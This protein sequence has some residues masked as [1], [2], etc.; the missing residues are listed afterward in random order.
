MSSIPPNKQM[1][2]LSHDS[3]PDGVLVGNWPLNV[4]KGKP[5]TFTPSSILPFTPSNITTLSSMSSSS[6][7]SVSSIPTS[8]ILENRPVVVKGKG[9]RKTT[10]TVSF[11]G[12]GDTKSPFESGTI[13]SNIFPGINLNLESYQPPKNQPSFNT[14]Q[15]DAS[16]DSTALVD[17]F[18]RL[19][20]HT[21]PRRKTDDIV[22]GKIASLFGSSPSKGSPSTDSP[23]TDSPVLASIHSKRQGTPSNGQK[24]PSRSLRASKKA[25][26]SLETITHFYTIAAFLLGEPEKSQ[27]PLAFFKQGELYTIQQVSKTMAARIAKFVFER[28]PFEQLIAVGIKFPLQTYSHITKM[29]FNKVSLSEAEEDS[30]SGSFLCSSSKGNK[31]VKYEQRVKC[32]ELAHDY[33]AIEEFTADNCDVD[34]QS[35]KYLE[36]MTK[37]VHLA[38]TNDKTITD[39]AIIPRTHLLRR[40][41]TLDLTGT[42]LTD[43]TLDAVAKHTRRLTSL[44]LAGTQVKSLE[45]IGALTLLRALDLSG[46]TNIT[47]E[48]LA[49]LHRC[50]LLHK[51]NV[52]KCAI[53]DAGLKHLAKINLLDEVN[54]SHC[55]GEKITFTG[56]RNSFETHE[57][58]RV[59][60]LFGVPLKETERELITKIFRN[61]K[62][63]EAQESR[64]GVLIS[65]RPDSRA[66]NRHTF[67]ITPDFPFEQICTIQPTPRSESGKEIKK[68]H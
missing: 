29:H 67:T 12:T 17:S 49:P 57:H 24:T 8:M 66:R 33:P 11:T 55:I 22:G 5:P 53:T 35:L 18:R 3:A 2:P 34:P 64:K 37:L 56:I 46:C 65:K 30:C 1:F 10:L 14:I 27:D 20:I 7:S 62:S 59:V 4:K 51:V 23:S 9:A 39:L 42:A 21:K 31:V 60:E 47:D 15:E 19:H 28:L 26:L 40:L 50:G 36:F 68:D 54:L 6:S 44:S 16:I 38:I 13:Q 63:K 52:S 48:S 58:I 32:N 25:P 61:K 41:T 45:K 43:L